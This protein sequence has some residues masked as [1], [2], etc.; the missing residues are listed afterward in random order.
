MA[1][2]GHTNIIEISNRKGD[3]CDNITETPCGYRYN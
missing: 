2:L 1:D 3:L